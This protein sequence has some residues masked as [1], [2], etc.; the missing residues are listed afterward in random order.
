MFVGPTWLPLRDKTNRVSGRA[1]RDARS[2]GD[3]PAILTA[4][5][6]GTELTGAELE[7]ATGA[8]ERRWHAQLDALRDPGQVQRTG[9]G[10]K[11]SPYRF[12]MLRTDAAQPAAQKRAE[13]PSEA[14]SSFPAPLP[15][16]GGGQETKA[17]PAERPQADDCAETPTGWTLS[18]LEARNAWQPAGEP[19]RAKPRRRQSSNGNGRH[20]LPVHGEAER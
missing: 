20:P 10:K 13:T 9:E 3:R 16:R 7:E 6:G 1:R 19:E 5:D 14:L 2:I 12:S 4:L 15:F 8:P 18:E 11:G 17:D